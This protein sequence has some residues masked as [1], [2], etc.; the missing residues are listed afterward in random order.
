MRKKI[1][2]SM[3]PWELNAIDKLAKNYNLTR[4]GVIKCLMIKEYCEAY[5]VNFTC[6]ALNTF[7]ESSMSEETKELLGIPKDTK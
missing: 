1:T 5:K 3:Q 6:C 2:V 7:N 4:S